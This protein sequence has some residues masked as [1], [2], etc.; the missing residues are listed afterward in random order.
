MK[1]AQKLRMIPVV[2]GSTFLIGASNCAHVPPKPAVEMCFVEIKDTL[3]NSYCDCGMT[4]GDIVGKSPSDL[5]A[6]LTD[7][8]IR[9][10]QY[11]DKATSFTP[12]WWKVVQ[13]Y[14]N[15][16][17]KNLCMALN[18]SESSNAL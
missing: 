5:R 15:D 16:L 2:I 7:K 6:S 9:P 11:C 12:D 10:I 18:C 13:D 14:I 1:S 3:E 17:H 4:N 8:V